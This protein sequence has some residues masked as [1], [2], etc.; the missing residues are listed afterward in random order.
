MAVK[1]GA[2]PSLIIR[3]GDIFT[4]SG[5]ITDGFIV[6]KNGKI[7]HVGSYG[8]FRTYAA[9][10][11]RII[12][13]GGRVVA[14]G[15][16]DIHT[17]GAGGHDTLEAASG[18][19]WSMAAHH[20][21]HGTTSFLPTAM[22]AS[23]EA[24]IECASVVGRAARDGGYP[25]NILGLHCE[26]PWINPKMK[27]AQNEAW[28]RT[29]SQREL[30][31]WVDASMGTIRLVTLAP[32]VAGSMDIIR[33]LRARGITASAGHSAASYETMLCAVRA[34]LSHCTHV[35]NTMPPLH[36]REPGVV[37]AALSCDQ[38]TTEAITDGF[39][40]H[41]EILKILL[42]C[43]G[44]DGLVL[45]TDSM[46]AAGMPDGEYELGGQKV[47]VAGGTA[48]LENGVLAG[49]TLTLDRAVRNVVEFLGVTLYDAVRFATINPARVIGV[50][51]R[52]GSLEVGKDADLIVTG[53]EG[54]VFLT[55]TGGR[56]TYAGED[57]DETIC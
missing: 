23:E 33:A 4:P 52:K 22:T 9:G 13:A 43:K 34:G 15:Y 1:T 6:I 54:N 37:G 24:L 19:L 55:I 20:A 8:E 40:L 41:P 44:L 50:D 5:I 11:S 14:P 31:R 16:I 10:D 57:Y 17:H 29:P 12:D 53:E 38:L 27:G 32:E 42:R 56:V 47:V 25:S 39:H 51:S 36:H 49:S 21:A 48:R 30:D 28:I 26:G 3:G 18:A 2:E 45:I 46:M 35:F 7:A